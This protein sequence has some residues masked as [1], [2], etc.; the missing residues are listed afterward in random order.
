[1]LEYRSSPVSTA[2]IQELSKDR[3]THTVDRF[4]L[5][6]WWHKTEIWRTLD[7]CSAKLVNVRAKEGRGALMKF[8]CPFEPI[9]KQEKISFFIHI[10]GFNLSFSTVPLV[11]GGIGWSL[12]VSSVGVG[13]LLFL[14]FDACHPQSVCQKQRKHTDRE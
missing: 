13:S 2:L 11:R 5:I 10:S 8:L 9:W 3:Q 14:P 6:I 7:P 4:A 1:M 12:N